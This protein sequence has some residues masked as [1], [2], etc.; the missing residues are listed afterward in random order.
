MEYLA[1]PLPSVCLL[2]L[3]CH[4]FFLGLQEFDW[5][6]LSPRLDSS[7][8][9]QLLCENVFVSLP[10]FGDV[11]VEYRILGLLSVFRISEIYCC[12]L[13]CSS[14]E[15]PLFPTVCF[16]LTIWKFFSL[17]LIFSRSIIKYFVFFSLT[18]IYLSNVYRAT[19]I[20]G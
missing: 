3:C 18:F 17:Y 15:I 12:S 20:C 9:L 6:P 2:L 7:K 16:I 8:S 13:S 10:L 1:S 5:Q 11:S 19:W 14:D 4:C